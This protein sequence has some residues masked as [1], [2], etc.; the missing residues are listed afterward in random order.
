MLVGGA[1]TQRAGRWVLER[2]AGAGFTSWGRTVS[3]VLAAWVLSLGFD[4]LLHAGILARLYVRETPFLLPPAEAFRRIPAGYLTFLLLTVG[5]WWLY[6]RLDI[7]GWL[8]GFRL[9]LG[10]GLFLWGAHAL[11]LWSIATAPVDLLAGWWLG[12]GFELGLAGAVL[13]S[14][15]AGTP[16]GRI[17][18][19]VGAAVVV[20]FLAVVA[21]QSTGIAP[22]LRAP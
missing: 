2:A 6:G 16:L 20:L 19:R 17:W 10:V 8:D 9:G 21:L 22:T 4:L 1:W 3:A 18:I 14:A 5:L 12:Q 11:G 13:G 15:R 7:R